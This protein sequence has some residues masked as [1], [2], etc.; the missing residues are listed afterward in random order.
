MKKKKRSERERERERE[1]EN[2][3][4]LREVT[5]AK[6]ELYYFIG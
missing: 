4:V 3:D 2:V 1:R 5:L 6:K